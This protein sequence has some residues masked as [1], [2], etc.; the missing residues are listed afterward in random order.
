MIFD[1]IN[2]TVSLLGSTLPSFSINDCNK[3][4]V[5]KVMAIRFSIHIRTCMP[6]ASPSLSPTVLGSF[7]SAYKIRW[8]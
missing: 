7:Q 8:I 5:D 1:T 3:F 6:D 4:F 2:N